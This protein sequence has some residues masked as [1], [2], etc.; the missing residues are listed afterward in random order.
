[1]EKRTRNCQDERLS[2]KGLLVLFLFYAGNITL[3]IIALNDLPFRFVQANKTVTLGLFILLFLVLMTGGIIFWYKRKKTSFRAVLSGGLF[4]F[5]AVLVLFLIEI[6]DF[7]TVLR[8]PILYEKFLQKTGVY[9]PYIFI[10]IQVVQVLFL[11]IPAVFSILVGIKLFGAFLASLYSFLGIMIG[12]IIAFFVGRALG[13]KAV[14]WLIG[15]D[16]LAL[17]HERLKGKDR[18]ILTAMFVLPFFPDDIL[19]FV[20]GLS[21]M[22]ISYFIIMS[23]C[24]RALSCFSTCYSIKLIPFNTWWGILLWIALIFVMVALFFMLYKN[25]GKFN[26]S[27]S[28]KRKNE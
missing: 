3:G 28:K 15:E 4:S 22:S 24:A 7:I 26:K 25:I 1:M 17:W 19:C 23:I 10:L 8:S 16:S 20:S 27:A 18:L 9:M 13:N 21:T 6:T 11:P 5:F 14:A 12:S 2:P